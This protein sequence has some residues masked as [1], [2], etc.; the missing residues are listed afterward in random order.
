MCQ[1]GQVFKCSSHYSEQGATRI[2]TDRVA[3]F[4]VEQN[5]YN[6]RIC[7]NMRAD[8]KGLKSYSNL[9]LRETSNDQSVIP[10]SERTIAEYE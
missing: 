6:D 2:L 1:G 5:D 3:P 10:V 4:W 9:F 7:M 8:D